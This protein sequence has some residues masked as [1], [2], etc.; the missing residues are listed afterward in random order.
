MTFTLD[1]TDGDARAGRLVSDHGA[2]ETPIFMP[3]GTVG[4]VKGV[5]AR[6]LREAVRAQ[7]ILGNTY[8]LLRRP[9]LGLPV[10]SQ[11]SLTG[12]G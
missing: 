11:S 7:V 4:T 10:R 1:A 6:E 8:H 3:V 12:V 9:G 2:I 5:S